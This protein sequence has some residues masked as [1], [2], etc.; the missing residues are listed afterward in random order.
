MA[1]IIRSLSPASLAA[2]ELVCFPYA[3]AGPRM[4]CMWPDHISSAANI[5]AVNLPA[6]ESRI[7]EPPEENFDVILDEVAEAIIP[8]ASKPLVL[9]GHSLG[10]LLAAHVAQ[11]LFIQ[12]RADKVVLIVSATR[13][14]W[15]SEEAF[16]ELRGVEISDDLV[17]AT[18]RSHGGAHA[19]I[20]A[21]PELAEIV[22][23]VLRAD[24]NLT[25]SAPGLRERAVSCPV[26]ALCGSRDDDVTAEMM[27][28]WSRFTTGTFRLHE[29]AGSH[30]FVDS[31]AEEVAQIAAAAATSLVDG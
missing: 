31:H 30:F 26:I 2:C 5:S 6:R 9:F 12:A 18:L 21:D 23:P 1:H 29:I 28:R 19:Q 25:L 13:P 24:L 10:G 3:G 7:S 22:V 16:P 27:R 15:Q 14:T 11:R 4:F 20:A 8:L 17:L